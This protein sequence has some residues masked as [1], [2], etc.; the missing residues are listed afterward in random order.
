MSRIEANVATLAG[1]LSRPRQVSQDL[2]EQSQAAEPRTSDQL[3]GQSIS[4][5][6]MKATAARLQQVVETASGRALDFK[7]DDSLGSL[8]MTVRDPKTQEIIKQIPPEGVRKLQVQ[9]QELVGMLVD[10]TA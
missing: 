2:Q 8:V 10:E 5:E 1:D 7:V 6:E 3:S 9:L 4:A